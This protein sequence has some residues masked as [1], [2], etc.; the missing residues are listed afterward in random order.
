MNRY[1]EGLTIPRGSL[2]VDYDYN[3]DDMDNGDDC[4]EGIDCPESIDT[5]N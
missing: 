3:D 1:P 4:P 2:I 5:N